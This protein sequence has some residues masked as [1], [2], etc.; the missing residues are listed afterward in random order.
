MVDPTGLL[1]FISPQ[2]TRVSLKHTKG[3]KFPA[4][5]NSLAVFA[6]TAY[7]GSGRVYGI[8]S[9]EARGGRCAIGFSASSKLYLSSRQGSFL[10]SKKMRIIDVTKS[11]LSFIKTTSGQACS[12]ESRYLFLAP[13][14]KRHHCTVS[15]RSRLAIESWLNVEIWSTWTRIFFNG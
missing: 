3:R 11:R 10:S 13:G 7:H 5:L 15:H 9:L 12:E 6:T 8:I 14:I 4:L 1:G 2:Q